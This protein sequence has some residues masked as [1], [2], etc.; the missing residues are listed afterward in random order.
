[1]A[2]RP[3][4]I[5]CDPG[6]DDA[7]ALLLTLAPGQEFDLLGITTVAGNVP[8]AHT[9][10]NAR[11][12]CA[13]ARAEVPVLAGCPRP[14]V[15]SLTTAEAIHGPTGL[16]GAELPEPSQPP[17]DCHGV[18]FLINQCSQAG[19]PITLATLGPLTNLAVALIKCPPIATQIAQVVVMGGSLGPGNITPA[20]EFN[21]YVDPH[22]AR[23]VVEAGLPLTLIGLDV[24]HQVLTTPERLARFAAL[25]NRVGQTVARW[26]A[27]YGQGEGDRYGLPGAPLHDPCVIAYL[28]QPDLFSG[29]PMYLAVETDSRLSRG[30]TIATPYLTPEYPATA[31]VMEEVDAE[32]VYELLWERLAR[33]GEGVRG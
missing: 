24:T 8:L 10:A 22:A 19:Q 21:F 23:V 13:L 3:L 2:K 7:V 11:R 32:G 29:R 20:A 30:R 31:Q 4:I 25:G 28:L 6:A 33:F 5:D 14:L 18:D 9:Y 27:H 15:H 1:M 26:L 12:V 17:L 16:A